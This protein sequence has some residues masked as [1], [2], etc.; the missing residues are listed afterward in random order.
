[1]VLVVCQYWSTNLVCLQK[2]SQPQESVNPVPAAIATPS[3]GKRFNIATKGSMK[4]RMVCLASGKL[5]SKCRH[6]NPNV[7][8]WP[9][10]HK[11]C[12]TYKIRRVLCKCIDCTASK[13]GGKSLCEHGL[14][15]HKCKECGGKSLCH[16]HIQKSRCVKCFKEGLRPSGLCEHGREKWRGCRECDG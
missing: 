14:Q 1:M 8:T 7:Y 10:G 9:D 4:G 15:K 5:K 3:E 6:C 12:S 16:H 11:Y 13:Q 2:G